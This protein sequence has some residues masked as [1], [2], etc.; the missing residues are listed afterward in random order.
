MR[1]VIL[2]TKSVGNYLESLSLPI[3]ISTI[4]SVKELESG[5]NNFT[6]RAVVTTPKGKL[7]LILKQARPFNKRAWR[8]GRLVR[9]SPK[10][11]EY[12]AAVLKF[13]ESLWGP[14]VVPKTYWLDTTN[15]ILILEDISQDSAYL[16]EE[17]AK[18]KLW[19]QVGTTLGKLVGK[20]HASTFKSIPKLPDADGYVAWVNKRLHRHYLIAAKKHSIKERARAFYRHCDKPPHSLVWFDPV[21]RNIFVAGRQG[22]RLI[23]FEIAQPHD[24]AWDIG[25]ITAPWLARSCSTDKRL[26]KDANLFINN[27]AK[28]YR[29][30]WQDYGQ[31]DEAQKILARANGYQGIYLL[32]RVDGKYGSKFSHDQKLEQAI[33]AMAL[34]LIEET[35]LP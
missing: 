12:E 21:D 8:Q 35:P 24:P 17:F 7:P 20:L 16:P 6:F 1:R 9:Q 2:T 3:E 32:S 23:D 26:Q 14:G 22:V 13:L 11:I 31:S 10:R 15:A 5:H 34:K 29:T 28:A 27:F 30:A 25:I 33:R 4:A 19:P 18:E